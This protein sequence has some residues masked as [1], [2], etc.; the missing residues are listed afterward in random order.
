MT[1]TGAGARVV[2]T[3]KVSFASRCCCPLQLVCAACAPMTT[4]I[5]PHFSM[6]LRWCGKRGTARIHTRPHAHTPA[7]ARAPWRIPGERRQDERVHVDGEP[8]SDSDELAHHMGSAGRCVGWLEHPSHASFLSPHAPFC[9]AG[10]AP[11][12]MYRDMHPFGQECVCRVCAVTARGRVRRARARRQGYATTNWTA[13]T[14]GTPAASAFV[15]PG[16][17]SCQQVCVCVSARARARRRRRS[18]IT[19]L[20]VCATTRDRMT[21]AAVPC[22]RGPAGGADA[23]GTTCM[24]VSYGY[25]GVHFRVISVGLRAVAPRAWV[26]P[27]ARRRGLQRA[28]A[29][30]M[31]PPRA[32]PRAPLMRGARRRGCAR[33][34]RPPWPSMPAVGHPTRR[35]GA[36]RG[37]NAARIRRRP[38]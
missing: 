36:P 28:L 32:R 6:G 18:A 7:P 33:G 31:L 5:N 25:G 3:K 30:P 13:F 11:V 10:S 8:R 34:Q 22:S 37:D 14:P 4:S 21:S 23:G 26:M 2:L 35:Q 24:H 38:K 1:A 19:K 20:I 16:A 15:V 29:R 12:K 17:A 27:S 9:H